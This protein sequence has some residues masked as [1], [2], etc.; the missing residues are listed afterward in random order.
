MAERRMFAKTMIG[1]DAFTDMPSSARLL[2]YD[3]GMRADDDGFINNPKSIMRMTGAS[4]DDLRLLIVK[5]FVINF[6]SGVVVIKHWNVNN[7]IPKDR[8]NETK[9]KEER[10]MLQFDE[11]K[12]YQL[13]EEPDTTCIQPVYTL[14]TQ[15]RLGKV[16]IVE[17]NKEGDKSPRSPTKFIEPSLEEVKEYCIERENKIDPQSFIDFYTTKG[18]M[19]GKNKM[20]DWRAAIRTWENREVKEGKT[21]KKSN[22]KFNSYESGRIDYD[23]AALERKLGIRR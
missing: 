16:S 21:P 19:V 9:Y 11:N 23:N 2:Y 13:I 18:W 22:N 5:K 14:E 10:L 1:S 17:I 7:Y 4:D 6:K 20:K 8:Y 3:F 15:V 12:S